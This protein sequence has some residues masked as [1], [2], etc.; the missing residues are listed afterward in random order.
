MKIRGHVSGDR[1]DLGQNRKLGRPYLAQM[2]RYGDWPDALAAYNGGPGHLQDW[3]TAGRAETALHCV[4]WSLSL[5]AIAL[6][7][8]ERLL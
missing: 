2:F 6:L 5:S 8:A 7:F 1:F 3:I 4:G